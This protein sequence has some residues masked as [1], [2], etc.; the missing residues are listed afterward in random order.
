MSIT[1]CMTRGHE[2][3]LFYEKVNLSTRIF[4]YIYIYINWFKYFG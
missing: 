2:G 1:K 4:E 3:G